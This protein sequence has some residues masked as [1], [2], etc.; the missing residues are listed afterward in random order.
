M[1]PVVLVMCCL[2]LAS[3][4]TA[5]SQAYRGP[6]SGHF[7][8]KQF[9]NDPSV[10][11]PNVGDLLWWSLTADRIPWPDWVAWP[12]GSG[13]SHPPDVVDGD[14]LR[15]TWVNHS[16]MLVQVGGMNILTDPVWS[17]VVGPTSWLGPRRHHAPGVRFEGLPHI[18]AVVLSHDHFD[19]L[20]LPT[21]RR[22]SARDAPAVFAGLGN[23]AWLTA[24]SVARA[25]ELDW[26]ECRTVRSVRICALPA[27]H[28]SRRGVADGNGSL[29]VSYWIEGA[30]G[31]VYFAGDTGFGPHFAQVRQRMGAPCVSLLPI[32]AYRPRWFMKGNHMDPEEAVRAHD[33]LGAKLGIAMHF[34]TF[35]QSD[36]GMYQ[37]GGELGLALRGAPHAPFVVPAF[38]EAR[39]VRCHAE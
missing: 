26:W 6:V 20:D 35:E 28:G 23:A 21:L 17:D 25:T 30:G 2:A 37:P 15:V 5:C 3:S 11:P 18:D 22:L 14:E 34:A 32:A 38:G 7:D 39:V 12:P 9:H 33:L 19:H 36:E 13:P 31:S 29:W 4:T 16:T 8:G 24:S 27:Q 1:R 10:V